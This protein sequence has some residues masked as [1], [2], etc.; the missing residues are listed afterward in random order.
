MA[1]WEKA[2]WLWRSRRFSDVDEV[3]AGLLNTPD[4]P[5]LDRLDALCLR[6]DALVRLK[7]NDQAEICSREALKIAESLQQ[8]AEV[9]PTEKPL[10]LAMAYAR[11]GRG[12]DAMVAMQRYVDA[13]PQ[14]THPSIRRF[15]QGLQADL[16]AGLNHPDE[17]CKILAALLR[18]PN[19]SPRTRNRLRV[20]SV[21]ALRVD[22]AWDNVREDPAFKA[23]IADPKNSAPL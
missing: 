6:H 18:I 22:P 21:P 3:L 11:C 8:V 10:W 7:R 14:E 17:A 13:T 1:T 12:N 20:Y 19:S 4:L 2:M 5:V 15:R 16:H 23:L 9:G